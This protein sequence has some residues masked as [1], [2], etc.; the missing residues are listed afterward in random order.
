[1]GG[2]LGKNLVMFRDGPPP[3]EEDKHHHAIVPPK[4]GGVPLV[5]GLDEKVKRANDYVEREF[6]ALIA[7]RYKMKDVARKANDDWKYYSK[8]L[9]LHCNQTR[10][11]L[12]KLAE[13]TD[14]CEVAQMTDLSN[15]F[16][17]RA[18]GEISGN[19]SGCVVYKNAEEIEEKPNCECAAGSEKDGCR[20]AVITTDHSLVCTHLRKKVL[21]KMALWRF[22]NSG[23]PC[24]VD[25]RTPFN[26][27][28]LP[29]GQPEDFKIP[30]GQE[31]MP[32]MLL[33]LQPPSR[34]RRRER[35]RDTAS[36]RVHDF[37]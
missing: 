6:Q 22:T 28:L 1:M 26:E 30:T 25:R 14:E 36:Q 9:E 16:E 11:A 17:K 3:C 21:P 29:M 35:N 31:A 4:L 37:L 23:G 24:L 34:P 5:P 27:P 8:P 20:S 15:L 13:K 7:A 33:M 10:E 18:K 2:M 32:P 19:I 12:F